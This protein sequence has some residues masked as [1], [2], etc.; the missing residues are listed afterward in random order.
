LV[1][2]EGR[3]TMFEKNLATNTALPMAP[4][5]WVGIAI[6]L[7]LI[8]GVCHLFFNLSSCIDGCGPYHN[9]T[10]VADLD[11]DGDLDVYAAML[12]PKRIR[13]DS[14]DRVLLNDGSGNFVDSGQR[15][16]ND[17]LP[18]TAGSAPSRWAT[19]TAMATWTL[20]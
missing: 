3:K 14:A 9:T 18:G 19:W 15:L 8:A 2:F 20:W 10:S 16:K 17:R 12:P 7:L 11:G 5:K 4:V 6:L 13:Y 1:A